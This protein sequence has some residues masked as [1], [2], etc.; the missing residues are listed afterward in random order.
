MLVQGRSMQ[1]LSSG[2]TRCSTRI[3]CI[4][5]LEAAAEQNARPSSF[6]FKDQGIDIRCV[7]D[8]TICSKP[9]VGAFQTADLR[10]QHWECN[11]ASY[12][13]FMTSQ[14]VTATADK[15]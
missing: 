12:N 8:E 2:S 11:A 3:N 10:R 14:C 5:S 15:G 13:R 9:S 1:A 7:A 6:E 4:A